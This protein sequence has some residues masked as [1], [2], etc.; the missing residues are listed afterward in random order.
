[1]AAV[2]SIAPVHEPVDTT[3]VTLGSAS[4]SICHDDREW[5]STQAPS[6]ESW[7]RL[8]HMLAKADKAA[9]AMTGLHSLLR[10]HHFA[11][12]VAADSQVEY[13]G[14][15]G[16]Q[17]GCLEDAMDCLIGITQSAFEDLREATM[18]KEDR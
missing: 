7:A 1:M 11:S 3:P 16:F 6:R 9:T 18:A 4:L 10:E 13:V 8:V 5:R 15:T 17:A 12:E 2:T 14:M